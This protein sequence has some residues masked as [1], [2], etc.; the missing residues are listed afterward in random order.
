MKWRISTCGAA[1]AAAAGPS[2]LT[3]CSRA[4]HRLAR[5]VSRKVCHGS[6]QLH[7]RPHG[8]LWLSPPDLH[9][10]HSSKQQMSSRCDTLEPFRRP[11][12][13]PI[14]FAALVSGRDDLRLY[15][16]FV[17]TLLLAAYFKAVLFYA[18]FKM[19]TVHVHTFRASTQAS[20]TSA[21]RSA[22]L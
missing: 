6:T 15:P 12:I 9:C 14:A 20:R 16:A 13:K 22:P 19:V 21:A 2:R 7:Q 11:N 5:S 4:C 1:A 3:S 18:H 10:C 8:C 17:A